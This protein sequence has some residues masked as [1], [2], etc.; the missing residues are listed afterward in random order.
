MLLDEAFANLDIN[1]QMEIMQILSQINSEEGK[2]I[3]LVSHNINLSAEYCDRIFLL[4]KGKIIADG[5]TEQVI[6]P[7]VLSKCII[8]T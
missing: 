6:N 3:I 8:L 7:Q 1:H 5:K 4:K 2:L